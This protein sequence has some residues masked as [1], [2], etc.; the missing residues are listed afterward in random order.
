MST[1]AR[2]FRA[3]SVPR[4]GGLLGGLGGG[5]DG[6]DGGGLLGNPLSGIPGLSNILPTIT[7]IGLPTPGGGS[8]TSAAT[9]SSTISL[10]S[11]DTSSTPTSTS[12]ST[13][14]A[15]S[16][17]SATSD[18]SSLTSGTQTSQST[19]QTATDTPTPTPTP[20][21]TSAPPS[22]ATSLPDSNSSST[23]S[24]TS[25][26]ASASASA[27]GAN[28]PKGFLQNKALSV[29]VITAASL[30]G[31]VLI[32]AIATWAIRKRRNDRLHQD[33]LD[34][35]TANL[36]S[37]AEKGSGAGGSRRDMF[38]EGGAADNG[39]STGHGSGS[40]SG[41]GGYSQSSQAQVQ[42]R[43]MYE[44]PGYS[45]LAAY[46]PNPAPSRAVNPYAPQ[47]AYA[48][49]GYAFP[50]QEQ[51]NTYANWGYA[52]Y[53]AAPAVVQPQ[54]TY[55]Q[56]AYGGMDD[57]YGGIAAEAAMAGVGAGA[58]SQGP[59]RRPS[60]HRKPPPQLYIPPSNPI[61]Q[62]V[63]ANGAPSPISSVSLTQPALQPATGVGAA[64]PP[65]R[66]TSLLNSPPPP[67]GSAESGGSGSTR[68]RRDTLTHVEL[69]DPAAPKAPAA[70][71]PL[72][73]EFGVGKVD[74]PATEPV[75]RL[76]VR[77]E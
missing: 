75:R 25:S 61:A 40:S 70:S 31:L 54:N 34:F 11:S 48:D 73:N 8:S 74:T 35:S 45:N 15:T 72:P 32:I 60:A 12:T 64:Q 44:N 37:D 6:N 50:T 27:I 7:P 38:A 30:V 68:E 55:D 16:S 17:T 39:S 20:T 9:T 22:D 62:A 58:Q 43:G 42:P 18:T 29:G 14:A 46:A 3:P 4:A 52:G 41:H 33:I 26:S 57:A 65:A 53:N 24:S 51:N 13:S 2:A 71:P 10:T 36:V 47:A 19:Q 56:A 21:P 49:R 67:A 69:L 63:A 28:A 77:N 1:N 23:S 66:R 76:V 5:D 59:Q